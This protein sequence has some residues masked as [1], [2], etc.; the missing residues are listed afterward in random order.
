MWV[1]IFLGIAVIALVTMV[2]YGVWLFHKAADVYAEVK[3]LGRRGEELAAL[4]AQLRAPE[5]VAPV[6]EE[7]PEPVGVPVDPRV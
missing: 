1:W 2:S 4:L 7:H 3:M 5:P 6:R